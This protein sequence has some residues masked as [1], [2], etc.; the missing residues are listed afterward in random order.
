MNKV[1][2]ISPGISLALLA[3][4]IFVHTC[5]V[6][7]SVGTSECSSFS[8][9]QSKVT[10]KS[11]CKDEKPGRPADRDCQ[12]NH[13]NFFKATGQ[14]FGYAKAVVQKPNSD[15]VTLRSHF[16]FPSPEITLASGAI[17]TGF[18]PPPTDDI[19]IFIRSF[20]I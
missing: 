4:M 6:W 14:Y 17:A 8:S 20:L 10:H 13:L 7:C 5:T 19:R 3:V 18:H 2:K 12:S 11:C 16:G 1:S 15:S 9:T